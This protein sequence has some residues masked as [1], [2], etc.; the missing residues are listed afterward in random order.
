[1]PAL[2]QFRGAAAKLTTHY[3]PINLDLTY[4]YAMFSSF[5]AFYPLFCNPKTIA[6]EEYY[7]IKMPISTLAYKHS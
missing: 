5:L 6:M 1:M 7:L 2:Q 3:L 4:A